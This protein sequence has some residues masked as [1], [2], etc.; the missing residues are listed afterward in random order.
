MQYKKFGSTIAVRIDRGEEIIASVKR[1]CE[2][3][4]IRLAMISAL[5]AVDHAVVGLYRVKEKRYLPNTLYGEYEMTSLSG[6][7]TR[8]DGEVYLHMHAD[9]ADENGHVFGGHLNEAVIS[10]TCE[11]FLTVID[12]EIGRKHDETTGLNVF[13][14]K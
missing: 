4:N 7:V 13:E 8:K 2:K 11:M 6:N 5:G 9:F 10:G 12:G 14:L 3:E 1:L